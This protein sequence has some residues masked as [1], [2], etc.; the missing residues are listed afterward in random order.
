MA[1]LYVI[2]RIRQS[3]HK[4]RTRKIFDFLVMWIEIVLYLFKS[5]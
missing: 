3:I 1:I 4:M 5:L 2:V